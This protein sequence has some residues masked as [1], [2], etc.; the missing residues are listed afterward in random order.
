MNQELKSQIPRSLAERREAANGNGAEPA[1]S[2]FNEPDKIAVIDV[3][4]RQLVIFAFNGFTFRLR[5]TNWVD[6]EPETV[7][8]Q[9]DRPQLETLSRKIKTIIYLTRE[10]M[11]SGRF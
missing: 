8:M 2:A 1:R 9:F 11:K 7:V 6:D 4:Y 10:G 5:N 3:P